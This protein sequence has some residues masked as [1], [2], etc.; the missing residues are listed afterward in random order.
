MTCLKTNLR[1]MWIGPQVSKTTKPISV[2]QI[3]D[4]YRQWAP[5]TRKYRSHHP[6]QSWVQQQHQPGSCGHRSCRTRQCKQP[7]QTDKLSTHWTWSCQPA[8]LTSGCH[9]IQS[10]TPPLSCS[11]TQPLRSTAFTAHTPYSRPHL[12][13]AP[14]SSHPDTR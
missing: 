6:T 2:T 4:R 11:S 7:V 13:W 9:V 12:Y 8:L 10:R 3:V 14:I 5:K 1:T